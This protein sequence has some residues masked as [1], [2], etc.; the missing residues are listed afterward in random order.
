MDFKKCSSCN[1]E[2]KSL[3]GH[4]AKSSKCKE[5]YSSNDLIELRKRSKEMT[6]KSK[7]EKRRENYDPKAESERK[8]QRYDPIAAAERR[9]IQYEPK[10]RQERYN[11]QQTDK[12]EHLLELDPNHQKFKNFFKEIQYGPI[13][14]CIC[15]M[16]CFADRGVHRLTDKFHQKIKDLEMTSYIDITR[17]CLKVNGNF[18]LC[19]TCYKKLPKKLM[20][21]QCFKNGLQLAEVPKCLQLSSMSNQLIA[22]YIL[23]IKFRE[24]PTTRMKLMNDRVS[25]CYETFFSKYYISYIPRL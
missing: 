6:Y 22:K 20:P 16:K 10:K 21:K 9:S 2:C 12:K 18:H 15:C 13:F 3:L 4:L 19:L 5:A 24:T 7:N 23:F 1:K 8:K 11:Q 25:S 14:P 17:D